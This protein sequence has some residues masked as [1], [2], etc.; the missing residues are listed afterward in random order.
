MWFFSGH[1]QITKLTKLQ[2][3]YKD[4][5]SITCHFEDLLVPT[6]DDKQF[7]ALD[8][9]TGTETDIDPLLAASS[10]PLYQIPGYATDH[11][12]ALTTIF[13]RLANGVCGDIAEL[14]IIKFLG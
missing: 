9:F 1:N 3:K 11:E 4:L 13:S 7:I 14:R 12:K 6:A 5:S 10:T 2:T 8:N